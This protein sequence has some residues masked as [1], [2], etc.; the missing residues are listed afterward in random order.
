MNQT[1]KSGIVV[2]LF[3]PSTGRQKQADLFEF[4]ASLKLH[5]EFQASKGY[6]QN[7]MLISQLKGWGGGAGGLFPWDGELKR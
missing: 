2:H 5:R 1:Y 4:K 3:S 6:I 7:Y